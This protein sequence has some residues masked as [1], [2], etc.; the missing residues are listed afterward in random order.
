MIQAITRTIKKEHTKLIAAI[1]LAIVAVTIPY[2]LKFSEYPLST[3][4]SDWGAF[5]S[6][7]GGILSPLFA[8]GSLYYVV[9]TFRQQ[10]FETTFNLL[11]EQHNN[12]ADILSTKRATDNTD[13]KPT[14][15]IENALDEL[16]PYWLSTDV[17]NKKSL[18]DNYD[19]HK[20]VRVV[21][22][23]LKFIDENCPSDKFKYSRI[24]RSF[25][26]ND[27]NLILAIN[28]A[29]LDSDGQIAFPKYKHL[30]E[31]YHL[32]EH[33]ILLDLATK[34]TLIGSQHPTNLMVIAGT[35]SP[36]AFGDGANI[37]KALEIAFADFHYSLSNK[38]LQ[39]SENVKTYKRLNVFTNYRL[40]R[41]H[42]LLEEHTNLGKAASKELI[43]LNQ[44]ALDL[45][46]YAVT[47]DENGLISDRFKQVF[48]DIKKKAEERI[49]FI[50]DDLVSISFYKELQLNH[51]LSKF[52][53]NT[54]LHKFLDGVMLAISQ[55]I[56]LLENE[57]ENTT[58]STE[59]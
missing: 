48:S 38:L 30:I 31:K 8:V 4:I 20:Y 6:Y 57:I 58:E 46:N 5:G 16:G 25:V 13:N 34:P 59:H 2:V 11:L 56:K 36:T 50:S 9:K 26:S 10:S 29:Q 40:D 51:T 15:S 53:C 54:P 14:S 21:Y 24:F 37:K 45:V 43:D 22:Q 52:E 55:E 18:N 12:L 17:S 28:C 44:E 42:G 35:F 41:L 7:V 23:I 1:G 27:L 3:Q 33:L 39:I 49:K 32:L 19:I 47:I